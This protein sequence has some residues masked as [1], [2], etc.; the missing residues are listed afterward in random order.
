MKAVIFGGSTGMGRALAEQFARR[1]AD[2]LLIASDARDLDAVRSDLRLK[3]GTGKISTLAMD[4]AQALP[5]AV[6]GAVL[7]D[8][9]KFDAM[10]LVAGLGDDG[11]SGI[12][13]PAA[14]ERL[15]KINFVAPALLIN[16]AMAAGALL[17]N[18]SVVVLSSVEA[19]R[20]RGRNVLY[21]A[22]KRGLE[23]YLEALCASAL[24]HQY[25]FLVFRL[26]YIDTAMMQYRNPWLPKVRLGVGGKEHPVEDWLAGRGC[27][28]CRFG[29]GQLRGAC[30]WCRYRSSA[31][32]AFDPAWP[33]CQLFSRTDLTGAASQSLVTL[34]TNCL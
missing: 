10:F 1:G 22:S 21:G 27:T 18:G 20:G 13:A 5:E 19:A 29:G 3:Y 33:V 2:A 7:A 16:A 9:G 30:N 26:G 32:W 12:L 15:V 4:L 28:I 11:D 14:A 31:A 34:E 6:V 24:G 8:F 17:P 25:Q 23:Q